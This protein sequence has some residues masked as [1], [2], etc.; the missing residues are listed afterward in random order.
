MR[1]HLASLLIVVAL[2]ALLPSGALA[3][4]PSQ[5]EAQAVWDAFW[6]RLA[7]G[8]FT[9]ARRYVHSAKQRPWMV[10]DAQLQEQAPQM[11]YCRIRPGPLPDSADDVLFEVHCE[12]GGETADTLVGFR[13]DF[14]GAWRISGM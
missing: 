4:A 13:Q 12:H 8:D 1:R 9:G 10:A 2:T 14:D 11:L 3:Q 5:A 7:A 6:G